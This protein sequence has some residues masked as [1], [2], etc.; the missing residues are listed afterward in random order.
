MNP[1]FLA[2]T[3]RSGG[4]FLMSL[5]NSTRKVGYVHEY[6]YKFNEG[7]KGEVAPTDA[8]IQFGFREFYETASGNSDLEFWGSKVD[9][10]E[11]WVAERWL[12]LNN[13]NPKSIR[14]IWLS[15]KNKLRQ[16]L[17][18]NK[19]VMTGIWHLHKEDPE[20]RKNSVRA[21]IEVDRM[22]LWEKALQF[23]VANDVWCQ[24]FQ[25]YDITP[26]I[27]FYEDFVDES[28]W[29]STVADIFNYLGVDYELPLEIST[30]RLKQGIS[31]PPESYLKIIERMV[32]HGIPLKYTNLITDKYYE[33]DLEGLL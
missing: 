30:T 8:D 31:N 7:W 1:F 25:T 4:F 14:W 32:T 27:L 19:S 29:E 3:Q 5:L 33:L 23:Y 18:Y 9:V 21:E 11:L 20:D 10:R 17:S 26:H 12:H 15:R 2:T 6:L 24:F 22:D 13:I 16:S 28:I